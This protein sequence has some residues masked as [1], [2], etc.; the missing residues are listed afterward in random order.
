MKGFQQRLHANGLHSEDIPIVSTN[1]TNL[2]IKFS[3]GDDCIPSASHRSTADIA[4]RLSAFESC[5][6][7]AYQN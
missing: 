4:S 5:G 2:A 6:S 3:G 1:M 7:I